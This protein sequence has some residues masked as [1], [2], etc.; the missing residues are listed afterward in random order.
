[1]NL[2]YMKVSLF[3]IGYKKRHNIIFYQYFSKYSNFLDA[4]VYIY[5]YIYI[6]I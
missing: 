5:I 2:E 4:P 3:E 1:M 6:Y